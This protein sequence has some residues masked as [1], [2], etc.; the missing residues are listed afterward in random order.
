MK[1][2]ID[3]AIYTASPE[4]IC[5]RYN[6]IL[7]VVLTVASIALLWANYNVAFF[8][9]H[10]MLSQWNLLISS[11]LLCTG[12]VMI[13][14]RLFGDSSAPYDRQSNERL[15]RS[16]YSFELQD[17]PKVQTAIEK[18]QFSLLLKLPRSYQ[19]AAQLIC[20]RT[21][22]GSLIA[23]QVLKNSKPAG[24]IKVFHAGEYDF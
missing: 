18:G 17:L 16:E 20:Y 4:I 21:D 9:E 13:C 15:Y 22:S 14:Y 10:E 23:A 1:N 8:A 6:P 19:P 3:D 11:C 5:R 2:T 12:I 7:G 24:E